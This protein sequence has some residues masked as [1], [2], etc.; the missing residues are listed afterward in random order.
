[1]NK[2]MNILLN[3]KVLVKEGLTFNE[4]LEKVQVFVNAYENKTPVPV[5]GMIRRVS[6]ISDEEKY[7]ENPKFVWD[8]NISTK[9][10]ENAI[11]STLPEKFGVC[12]ITFDAHGF[13]YYNFKGMDPECMSDQMLEQLR[14]TFIT[15]VNDGCKQSFFNWES[16]VC[17]AVIYNAVEK[18]IL[19]DIE[20]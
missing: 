11:I 13:P 5:V 7:S 20:S 14:S 15:I 18:E 17:R 3:G 19:V 6:I 12:V 4:A 2:D 1:M 16:A 9:E 8:T 10:L